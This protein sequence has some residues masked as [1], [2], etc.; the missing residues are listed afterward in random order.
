MFFQICFETLDR[1]NRTLQKIV[2][3]IHYFKNKSQWTITFSKIWSIF[4]TVKAYLSCKQIFINSRHVL[5][6]TTNRRLFFGH[7]WHHIRTVENWFETKT[8]LVYSQSNIENIL[9]RC[10]H[11]FQIFIRINFID[12]NERQNEQ[13]YLQNILLKSTNIWWIFHRLCLDNMIIQ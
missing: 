6:S 9:Y 3:F 13:L 2:L 12:R 10:H 4:T 11:T 5:L 1:S 8:I 7:S